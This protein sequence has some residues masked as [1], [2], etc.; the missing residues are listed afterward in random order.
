MECTFTRITQLV[1]ARILQLWLNVTK[2]SLIFALW[3]CIALM[4]ESPLLLYFVL[5]K[6]LNI[7]E[8]TSKIR[9][10]V[11]VRQEMCNLNEHFGAFTLLSIF[12]KTNEF[13]MRMHFNYC[14]SILLRVNVLHDKIISNLLLRMRLNKSVKVCINNASLVSVIV[15]QI[16]Y[17]NE[18]IEKC[19]FSTTV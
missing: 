1:R 10:R 15:H 18:N 5:D 8:L 9:V 13:L 4:D 19:G 16:E 6:T 3:W 7:T 11:R 14:I 2:K 12:T 17:H